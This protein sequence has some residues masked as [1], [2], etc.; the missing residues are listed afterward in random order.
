MNTANTPYVVGTK[1]ISTGVYGAPTYSIHQASGSDL[2]FMELYLAASAALKPEVKRALLT[3]ANVNGS[4]M[5]FMS[6]VLQMLTRYAH[7]SVHFDSNLYL[8]GIA[9]R[10]TNMAHVKPGAVPGP[11]YN[12]PNLIARANAMTVSDI[13]PVVQL[14][15]LSETFLSNETI[16][17]S[18][19][20]I[21]RHTAPNAPIRSIDVVASDSTDI[22]G[23][24]GA[25]EYR[26]N[27]IDSDP[28]KAQI[29]VDPANP[30]HATI[31]FQPSSAT[32]RIDVGVFV[33]KVGGTY[34]SVPGI[35]SNYVH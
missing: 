13:P 30:A 27:V 17:T 2:P 15:V 7:N 4:P 24:H 12:I 23:Q 14:R 29:S 10:S 25:F 28:T 32:D 11:A 26:W 18:P 22:N 9:H 8:G 1:Q 35:I 6:P 31:T 19:G 5:S 3:G 33:R 16:F 34:Y 20:S 21:A